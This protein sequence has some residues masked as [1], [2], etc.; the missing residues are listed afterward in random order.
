MSATGNGSSFYATYG[1]GE[2]SRGDFK[3][4]GLKGAAAARP[5]AVVYLS[6]TRLKPEFRIVEA[7]SLTQL[8][9]VTLYISHSNV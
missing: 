5:T 7:T 9:F 3:T 1:F 8:S 4:H 2:V 6:I